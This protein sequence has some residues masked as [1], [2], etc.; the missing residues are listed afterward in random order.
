MP[1]LCPS[2]TQLEFHPPP[3]PPAFRPTLEPDSTASESSEVRVK[4]KLQEEKQGLQIGGQGIRVEGSKD[5]FFNLCIQQ[6]EEKLKAARLREAENNVE[7]SRL[8]AQVGFL[9]ESSKSAGEAC[10]SS[11]SGV[12]KSEGRGRFEGLR[13]PGYGEERNAGKM[14]SSEAHANERVLG[15]QR[16]DD[17]LREVTPDRA[18][19]DSNAKGKSAHIAAISFTAPILSKVVKLKS[20]IQFPELDQWFD[21]Q[22]KHTFACAGEGDFGKMVRGYRD[23]VDFVGLE[24][25]GMTKLEGALL[26]EL[27][28]C[29]DFVQVV[30]DVEEAL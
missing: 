7:I 24:L 18:G 19:G 30:I 15:E 5:Y 2:C 13:A 21:R 26:R 27:G 14:W 1:G 28:E 12:T 22:V 17:K 20:A 9:I 8:K 23:F 4:S 29:E 3:A 25:K 10:R 6:L 11:V 16:V